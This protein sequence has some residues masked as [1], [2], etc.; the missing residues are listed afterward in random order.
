MQSFRDIARDAVRD[1]VMRQAWDLFGEQ[2][3]EATTID[4]IATAAGMSRRTFF[5]YFRSKD[6]L[7][8]ERL[9]EA[10]SQVA[11]E[12]QARPADEGPWLALRQ[13]FDVVIRRQEEYPES[14]RTIGR[15]LQNEPS[16]R[17]NME[18]R[19][20]RWLALLIP[21]LEARLVGSEAHLQAVG[22]ASAAL[23]C[24]DSAQAAWLDSTGDTLGAL[25]DVVMGAVAPLG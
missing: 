20:R 18:E 24:L 6:E 2:G 16:A 12:L 1:E 5:R 7:L 11:F 22:L 9:V 19:R 4:Q 15:M 21:A 13:A 23:A 25:L 17:A 3:F 14:A 10:G 8:L